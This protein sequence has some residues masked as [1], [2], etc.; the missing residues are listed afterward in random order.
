M[1]AIVLKTGHLPP[2]LMRRELDKTNP[3]SKKIYVTHMKPQLSKLI[4]RELEGL[5]IR[6]L[7]SL[8]D[9][10]HIRF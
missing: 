10:D 8:R 3:L 9:G 2:G 5:K 1:E 7:T 4:K 6:N